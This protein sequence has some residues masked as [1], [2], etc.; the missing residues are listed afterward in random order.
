MNENY[1]VLAT[2]CKGYVFKTVQKLEETKCLKEKKETLK[3]LCIHKVTQFNQV[4]LIRNRKEWC[5]N[6][7][8]LFSVNQSCL[9]NC[10]E[11][12]CIRII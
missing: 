9:Q 11:G 12:Y 3:K 8:F 6:I 4:T 7:R 1:G 2:N 5:H 10:P